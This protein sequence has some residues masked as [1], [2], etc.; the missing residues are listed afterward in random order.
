MNFISFPRDCHP[1]IFIESEVFMII[2]EMIDPSPLMASSKRKITK[3]H[4]SSTIIIQNLHR[5]GQ[6]FP[7]MTFALAGKGFMAYT[8]RLFY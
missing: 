3:N 1:C 8:I 2:R 6:Q 4:A 5:R 7:R